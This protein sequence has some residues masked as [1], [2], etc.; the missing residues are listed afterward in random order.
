METIVRNNES[1]FELPNVHRMRPFLM[2]VVS[3]SNHWL[4]IA[5]NGGI[6]AGRRDAD[7]ALF[8]YYTDDKLVANA[9]NTGSKT[10]IHALQ[11]NAWHLWKPF[12]GDVLDE[13]KITRT[14]YKS[15]YGN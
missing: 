5:S 14:L 10:I 3:H 13:P 12:D 1:F 7:I 9:G 11:N 4:F 15:I 8:P 2:S 6:S